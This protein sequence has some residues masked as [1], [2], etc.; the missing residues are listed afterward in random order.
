MGKFFG[1]GRVL[2]A[3]ILAVVL[4][5][6]AYYFASDASRP[7]VAQASTETAILQAIAT[8]DSTG[9]GLPD[10]QKSLYGIPLNATTTDYFGLGMTDGEAV[11]KGLIVPKAIADLQSSPTATTTNYTEDGLPPPPADNTLTAQFSQSFLK[12]YLAAKQ[13]NGGND[14]SEAQIA[15]VSSKALAQLTAMVASAPD[16]KSAG[17]LT[18]SGSGATAMK[19]FAV[20]TEGVFDANRANA[21]TS[22]VNYLSYAVIGGDESAYT[23]IAAISK[24]YRNASVALS[25][26][27]VPREVAA[28]DLALINAL[29]RMGQVTNDFT[30]VNSDPLATMLALQEYPNAVLALGNS[31]IA[32]SKVYKDAG[33]IIPDGSPGAGVINLVADVMAE[34]KA[35]TTTP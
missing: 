30:L 2:G 21:T 8:K 22:E 12:L 27:A 9:D 14:L 23:H 20:S 19:A 10:W 24:A 16:F 18:V 3:A 25:Q 7:P 34:Q 13:T 17:D 31:L 5:G 6:G 29:A 26:V 1:T 4:V 32:L 35:A 11:A 28:V 15:D 33:I